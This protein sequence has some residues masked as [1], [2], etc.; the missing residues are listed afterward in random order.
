MTANRWPTITRAGDVASVSKSEGTTVRYY[1]FD[2]FEVHYDVIE[3]RTIQQWHRHE[4]V[5]ECLLVLEGV[6]MVRW[7][8]ADSGEHASELL[9]V[10]D[11]VRVG[12][13][14]HS[15]ENESDSA[16]RAVVFRHVPSGK[17]RRQIFRYDKLLD[18]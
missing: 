1:C 18:A 13:A 16:V 2:E 17:S 15:F 6:L 14:F 12:R 5:E 4:R 8:R 3:P 10:G 7:M 11:L 9:R